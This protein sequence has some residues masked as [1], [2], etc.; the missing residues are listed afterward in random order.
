MKLLTLRAD[1]YRSLRRQ[2]IHLNDFNLFIG[3]NAS[4]K[5]TI[6]DVLR[7]LSEAVR[8]RDFREP[9]FARGGV[10]H[11]AWKGEDADRIEL[12]VRLTDTEKEFEW[13]IRLIRDGYGFQV[14]ERLNELH[15][16]SPPVQLLEASRGEGWW[17]SGVKGKVRLRLPDI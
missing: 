5:S 14:E 6:L 2:E 8:T 7:F 15:L 3:G 11:L 10:L 9:V 13:T 16:N 1:H 4:G 17:W 12:G